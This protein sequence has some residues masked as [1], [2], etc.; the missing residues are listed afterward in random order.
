MN[1]H[2]GGHVDYRAAALA[3]HDGKDGVDEVEGA[4]EVDG[5]YGVP[6]SLGHAHHQ[7]VFGYAGVVDKDVDAAEVFYN[8]RH[9]FFGPG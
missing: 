5:D 3:H 6:L 9:N 8:L 4:F 1:A 2:D 7:T